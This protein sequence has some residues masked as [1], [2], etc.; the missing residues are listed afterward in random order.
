[1]IF[2][3]IPVSVLITINIAFFVTLL[4]NR[5]LMNCWKKKKE[6]SVR[7]NRNAPKIS[8]EQEE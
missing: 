6:I 2:F 1:M 4:F 7:A 3:Y 8:K 5:N